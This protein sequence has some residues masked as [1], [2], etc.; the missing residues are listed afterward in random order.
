MGQEGIVPAD[1]LGSGPDGRVTAAAERYYGRTATRIA[2][3][4]AARARPRLMSSNPTVWEI[5]L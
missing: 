1:L 5:I 4:V 3:P 2:W